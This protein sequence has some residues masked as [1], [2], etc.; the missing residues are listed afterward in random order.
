MKKEYELC[1]LGGRYGNQ[2]AYRFRITQITETKEPDTPGVI[3]E[4]KDYPIPPTLIFGSCPI[5]NLRIGDYINVETEN[6]KQF[7][8]FHRCTEPINP[9]SQ[10]MILNASVEDK[11]KMLEKRA[12][13]AFRGDT[14]DVD[15][16]IEKIKNAMWN[17]NRSERT[18]F[19]LWVYQK[20]AK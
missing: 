4:E 18:A 6:D 12:L 2:R 10:D 11:A 9:L 5:K 1:Y 14:N 17:L 15:T 20:L 8:N 7:K 19:A 3:L 16:Y 13:N